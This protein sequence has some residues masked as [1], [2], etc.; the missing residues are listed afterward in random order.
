MSRSH[1]RTHW[2]TSAERIALWFLVPLLFACLL[3]FVSGIAVSPGSSHVKQIEVAGALWMAWS[4]FGTIIVAADLRLSPHKR[5][6]GSAFISHLTLFCVAVFG[7]AYLRTVFRIILHLGSFS[8]LRFSRIAVFIEVE[9]VW[10]ILIYFLVLLGSRAYQYRQRSELYTHRV[11]RLE[12][13]L[14]ETQLNALRARL[15][16][17]F[18][19]NVLNA[20]SSYIEEEPSA[21]R[22]MIESLSDLLRVA[23]QL[24]NQ[25]E[26][27]L[28]DEVN[29]LHHY[30]RLQTMRFG[31]RL[32]VEYQIAD[33]LLEA[34]IPS[35]LLQP[36]VE[37]AIQHGITPQLSGGHV[38]IRALKGARNSLLIEVEDD[39]VGLP[40]SFEVSEHAGIGLRTTVERLTKLFPA[41][42]QNFS[43]RSARSAGTVARIELPLRFGIQRP[44]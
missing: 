10:S 2:T 13:L 33:D 42:S 26:V 20:I 3:S 6:F 1:A 37:N 25:N 8:D 38:W 34:V 21:A 44:E 36:L 39:G 11:D 15:N 16:P 17:H 4:L 5:R 29:T 24:T 30:T 40:A 32:Q 41:A 14:V 22:A 43:I 7:T 18:L 23:F 9:L 35:F 19:F 27:R 12:R 31:E 28:G